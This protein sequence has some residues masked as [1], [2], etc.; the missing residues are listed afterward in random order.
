[1]SD[2]GCT[3]QKGDADPCPTCPR[4]ITLLYRCGIL[5][6]TLDDAQDA[7]DEFLETEP[8]RED[9]DEKQNTDGAGVPEAV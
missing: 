6:D 9:G 5:Q 2:E 3:F 4:S 1:M 7:M 8:N